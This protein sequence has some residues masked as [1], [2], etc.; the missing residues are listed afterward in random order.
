MRI[1]D[2]I[3]IPIPP[4][5][6]NRRSGRLVELTAPPVSGRTAIPDQFERTVLTFL[7][8]QRQTLG[9]ARLFH[10]ENLLVDG[11]LALDDGRFLA[12]EIKYRM[13][14][15]KAC[16]TGW[17]FG[18]FTRMP[19]SRQYRPVGGIVFFEEFSG[20]WA[21]RLGQIER[22]WANWYADHAAL[23]GD[24]T[25]RLDLVRFRQGRLETVGASA[26]DFGRPRNHQP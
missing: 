13:N 15:L 22:G 4:P 14:W 9:V 12:V 25:F 17:Q 23:P 6:I 26:D 2:I 7:I 1:A 5:V 19:E 18:Q 16:Q 8:E 20:D 21:R 24:D 3:N 11:A 10:A